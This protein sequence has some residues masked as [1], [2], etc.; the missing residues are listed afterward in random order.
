MS[1]QDRRY[2]V[3]IVLPVLAACLGLWGRPQRLHAD[4]VILRNLTII[5]DRTVASFDDAG[6]VLDNDQRI[7]WYEI[8]K[9]TLAPDKQ[10]AFDKLLAELGEPLYRIRQRLV[11]ADYEGLLQPAEALYPRYAPLATETAYLVVQAVMWGRL[12]AGQREQALAPYLRCLALLRANRGLAKSLPG[13]RRL[14]FDPETGLT[15]DLTPVWFDADAARAALPD[16]RPRIVELD[17]PR[18]DGVFIYYATLAIAAGDATAAEQGLAAIKLDHPRLTEL[19]AIVD[20]QREVQAGQPGVGVEK[21]A[22]IVGQLSTESRSLAWYWLGLSK[23]SQTAVEERQAGQLQLL[24]IPALAGRTQSELAA[25]ALFQVMTALHA[26]GAPS[27][28]NA[29]RRELLERYGHTYYAMK[30]KNQLLPTG[31]GNSP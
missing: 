4:R 30:A 31:T 19:R 9:A 22:S 3:H 27:E 17:R 20:A 7:P 5:S 10:A 26:Q 8:E 11:T 14:Q 6:I 21:L 29:V 25:A 18:P 2:S 24:R 16:V 1:C 12:A 13:D 23:L 28:S 15:P